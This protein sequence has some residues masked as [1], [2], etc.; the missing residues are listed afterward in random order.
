MMYTGYLLTDKSRNQLLAQFPP[1]Y[2][3]TVAHHVTE[4]FGTPADAE[5]PPMPDVIAVVGYIDSGDGVEGLLVAVNG[6][7]ERPDGSKYHCTWSLDE[8][9]KAVETNKYVDDAT[10]QEPIQFEVEPK[11]FSKLDELSEAA[12]RAK[13]NSRPR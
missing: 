8:G 5:A 3:K 1:K 11:N 7:T 12:K 13:N 2:K 9:R 4:A 6:K 10:P